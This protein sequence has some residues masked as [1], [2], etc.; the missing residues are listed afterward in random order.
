METHECRGLSIVCWQRDHLSLGLCPADLVAVVGKIELHN[1]RKYSSTGSAAT[2]R[3]AA[4]P[5]TTLPYG[6]CL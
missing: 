6:C 5:L 1:F 4:S 2:L 3:E